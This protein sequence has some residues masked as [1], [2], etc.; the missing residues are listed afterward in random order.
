MDI[1]KESMKTDPSRP[2]PLR[3]LEV[4]RSAAGAEWRRE[5]L[6]ERLRSARAAA[7]LALLA[8]GAI[9]LIAISR[10]GTDARPEEASASRSARN[11]KLHLSDDLSTAAF[12]PMD[13]QAR[14]DWRAEGFGVA[15]TWEP[16]GGRIRI[17]RLPGTTKYFEADGGSGQLFDADVEPGETYYYAACAYI[18][19][20]EYCS[21]SISFEAPR[22]IWR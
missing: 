3:W 17:Y 15:L 18:G 8:A 21:D 20:E 4:A 10:T 11:D 12:A 6:P 16:K 1:G 9:Y 19:G 7:T 14:L 5:I 13:L 2:L 22:Q